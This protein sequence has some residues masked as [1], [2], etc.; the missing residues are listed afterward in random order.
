[1][2]FSFEIW[3]SMV[4]KLFDTD[5]YSLKYCFYVLL[6][7]FVYTVIR[8]QLS[9]FSTEST[10]SQNMTIFRSTIHVQMQHIFYD[11]NTLIY[12]FMVRF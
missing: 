8:N 7:L 12:S 11:K 5:F 6:H 10:Y 9:L 1:M 3:N 2:K 4:M